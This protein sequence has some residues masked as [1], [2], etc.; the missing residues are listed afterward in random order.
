M[1]KDITRV[2]L[3]IA[4]I[5]IIYAVVSALTY[6]IKIYTRSGK[7]P[8]ILL[9]N[10]MSM[11]MEGDTYVYSATLPPADTEGRVIAYDTAHMYLD[12]QIDGETVYLLT[13]D[14]GQGL[15]TTGYHWN[16]IRLS[17][18]DAGK[19]IIFR[20]T[21]AYSDC[22]PKGNFYYGTG[23]EV[24]H[25]IVK[26]RIFR[27]LITGAILLISVSLLL[28]IIL[29][30]K[31][32]QRDVSLL[33]FTVFA[34]MLSVWS[35]CETQMV[36]FFT[37]LNISIVFLDHISLM[38]MPI[39]FACFLR[40]MYQCRDSRLW[41]YYCFLNYGIIV[42]RITAQ[43]MGFLD[44]RETLLL[45]HLSIFIL[46]VFV[47][48]ISIK[49]LVSLKLTKQM[50]TD[51]IC[52]FIIMV[53]AMLELF[54]Y[55]LKNISVPIGSLGFLFYTIM[56][57][58]TG[59][60]KSRRLI[61]Q[62]REGELYKKLAFSDG[63]TGINNRTAFMRDIAD[64]NKAIEET[65]KLTAV[66]MFDLNDL[67]KCNDNY[68]HEYGDKYIT[69]ISDDIKSIFGREHCYRIGGDEFCVIKHFKSIPEVEEAAKSFQEQERQR[70]NTDFVVPVSVA[71]G[72]AIYDAERDRHLNDTMKRADALMYQ[73][74]RK[75]KG[76]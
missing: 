36:E 17:A 33:H 50:R 54:Q 5:G 11:E 10:Q 19:E 2:Y 51:M 3:L 47:F 53:T 23:D 73:D 66:F 14:I 56:M 43:A 60:R 18:G 67:K 32:G 27:F 21:P 69:M 26:G 34:I 15:K 22:K 65:L 57:G 68:G 63:L 1:R 35:I 52:V 49:E 6:N 39:A 55:R 37:N 64:Y 75:K 38:S 16:F 24:E 58:L 72:Y 61:E 59:I 29:V 4:F 9:D 70:E 45:T 48:C 30:T 7:N 31:K 25:L 71:V 46:P 13:S 42:F 40:N 20:V 12:V 44:L 62:T 74:K 8:A 41:D 28:Y 76:L